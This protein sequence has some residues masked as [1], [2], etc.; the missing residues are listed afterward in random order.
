[1]LGAPV[2]SAGNDLDWAGQAPNVI[3]RVGTSNGAAIAGCPSGAYSTDEG[4]GWHTFGTCIP[5]VN[6]SS[7]SGGIINVDASG[8]FL[9][10]TAPQP[11]DASIANGPFFSAD[12]GTTWSV[13]LGLNVQTDYIA[14]D[15]VQAKTF[16]AFVAGTFY[17]ST[18]GGASYSSVAASASGLPAGASVTP[19]VSLLNAGE[20]WLPIPG[21]GLYHS[22]NFGKKFTKAAG[23]ITAEH[24]AVGM[25]APGHPNKDALYLW[26]TVAAGGVVGLYRSDD[27][28]STWVRWV[29]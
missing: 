20:V 21:Q 12:M 11:F 9:T 17:V 19:V 7:Y 3:V 28:A 29:F 8:K 15:K 6:S 16:Y 24:F 18:D 13:P 14:S 26:G 1:M 27:G 23:N 25:H 2:F 10:W 22:T 5:G 4:Q